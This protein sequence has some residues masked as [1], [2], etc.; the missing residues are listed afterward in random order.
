MKCNPPCYSVTFEL[1]ESL[2]VSSFEKASLSAVR[3]SEFRCLSK[4]ACVFS[5][6][7]PYV[8]ATVS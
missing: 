2:K 6:I 4:H 8:T 1:L 3:V 7:L 5:S